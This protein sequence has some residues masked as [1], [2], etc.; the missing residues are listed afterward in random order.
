MKLQ[1][2]DSLTRTFEYPSETSLCEEEPPA[3]PA[4]LAANTHLGKCA[5]AA[6]AAPT[7]RRGQN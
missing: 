7:T 2:D 5:P 6:R 3:A 4:Q 1:F